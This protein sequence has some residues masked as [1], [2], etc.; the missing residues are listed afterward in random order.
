M[1]ASN[2][3]MDRAAIALSDGRARLRPVANCTWACSRL[4]WVPCRLRNIRC[5]PRREGKRPRLVGMV[6]M[7]VSDQ[8]HEDLEG[9]VHDG[10][11]AGRSFEL[12]FVGQ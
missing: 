1:T 3:R 8:V 6:S 5:D 10:E 2:D 11:V 4:D 9:F 12:A 7:A